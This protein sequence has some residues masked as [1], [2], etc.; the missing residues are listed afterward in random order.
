VSQTLDTNVLVYSS[1]EGSP[2]HERARR[3]IEH[4][5]AGSSLLVVFWPTIL[6]YLRIATHPSIFDSPLSYDDAM[7]NV[8]SL[9]HRPQVRLAGEDEEFWAHYHRVASEL[10]PR[11]NLVPD[12][13]LVALMRQHG[14]STVWSHDR[15]F[16][17][18][19]GIT[20]RDPFDERY[21]AGFD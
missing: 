3:L 6:G 4:L 14:I 16:R 17:K 19:S 2:F 12:T 8:T 15:D 7:G 13:H 18:F 20:V 21:S 9:L 1:N 5:A 10:R 11:G